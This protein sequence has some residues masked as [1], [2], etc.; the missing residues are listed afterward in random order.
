[1]IRADFVGTWQVGRVI[2]DRLA[3]QT[4]RFDGQ[5]VLSP[6]GGDGLNYVETGFLRL[7]NGPA[8]T[9]TRRYMWVFQPG[10]VQV[11][12]DDGRPFHSF[13]PG[14]DGAGTD[15]LC[16]ADFYRVTYGFAGWPVW[17]AQWQVSGPRKDYTLDSRYWR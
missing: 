6:R 4:G 2:S 3:G 10:L 12:F 17:T 16:A 5:V 14:V 15:H 9:A 7:G 11:S 8:L 1:V 13:T